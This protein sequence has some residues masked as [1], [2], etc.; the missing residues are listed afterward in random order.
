MSFPEASREFN[1]KLEKLPTPT[2]AREAYLQLATGA[3]TG[4]SV[5]EEMDEIGKEHITDDTAYVIAI[6]LYKY[7]GRLLRTS[8]DAAWSSFEQVHYSPSEAKRSAFCRFRKAFSGEVAQEIYKK[9]IFPMLVR[10]VETR[11]ALYL[12]RR[13]PVDVLEG[14]R[15]SLRRSPAKSA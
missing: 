14:V 4:V 7:G 15:D 2:E 11:E 10:G 12:L 8:P 13:P 3:L 6:T 1:V 9:T 5:F